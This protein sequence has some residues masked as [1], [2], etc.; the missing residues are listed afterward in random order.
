MRPGAQSAKVF[1]RVE[2]RALKL[3]NSNLGKPC[4]HGPLFKHTGWNRF[5]SLWSSERNP[6]AYKGI[7]D[8]CVILIKYLSKYH[9]LEGG[10]QLT[11][12]FRTDTP[13]GISFSHRSHTGRDVELWFSHVSYWNILSLVWEKQSR[14]WMVLEGLQCGEGEVRMS[15]FKPEE[16]FS[17]WTE[18]SLNHH[19]FRIRFKHTILPYL[20]KSHSNGFYSCCLMPNIYVYFKK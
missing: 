3:F 20:L 18:Q 1:T 17:I 9:S 7:P 10:V 5:G 4:R 12:S 13:A 11:D 16:L 8:I 15:S 2:V 14:M 19:S 6:T